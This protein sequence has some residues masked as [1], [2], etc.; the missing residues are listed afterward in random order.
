MTTENAAT[1]L[2][3]TAFVRA[4]DWVV[5][6]QGCSEALTLTETLVRQ[7]A[8]IGRCRVFLGPSFS[9]TFRPEH[10]D[11]IGFTA[12]GG[13]GRNQA[14][15]R[16]DLLDV[17]PSHYSDLP[18]LFAN[19]TLRCDVALLQLSP[20]DESGRY[21]IGL[22]ND[23]QIDAAR[24]ARVVIAE[25]N[26]QAPWTYGAEVPEDIHI[27]MMVRTSRPPAML[28]PASLGDV[29][30]RIAQHVAALVP[31]GATIELGIGALPEAVL[32][33]LTHHR[34][35]GVHSGT[36]G[37]GVVDLIETGVITNAEKP[38]DRGITVAGVLF[39]GRRLFDFAH[40]NPALRLMPPAY[41][42]GI[43]MLRRM[44]R[45]IAINS[46][47]EV[48]ITG[49]VNGE[50]ASGV[51]LGAVGGQVDFMRGAAAAVGGRS[52]IA[53]PA[54]ARDGTVSRIVA[55]IGDGVVTSLRSDM[56]M[57]VT[58]YGVAELRGRSLA[59]RVRRM[60]A[61]AAPAFGEGLERA[62]HPL[63]RAGI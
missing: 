47:I 63:L 22:A 29:E 61:I 55:R 34:D 12:Y 54:T 56:D 2:D 14:L 62:A 32:A 48:D 7:R 53:L 42:H 50:V 4:G 35:I 51:Y 59:E 19:G 40:R 33:A 60:I 27:D 21:N 57:V 31:D 52:I 20:S 43:D 44:P 24:G 49:Q 1:A 36:I 23:Y 46:A 26:D 37:D 8:A 38:V 16:A 17:V 28:S 41:T 10:A 6:G 30:A 3:L 58:E 39:G 25:V 5:C 9:G 18:G 13:S 11:H 45:F 15:A